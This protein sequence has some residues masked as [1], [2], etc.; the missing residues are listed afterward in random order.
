[1]ENKPQTSWFGS[2]NR[3]EGSEIDPRIDPP[4]H[5]YRKL[6]SGEHGYGSSCDRAS[7]ANDG[8]PSPR[9]RTRTAEKEQSI[10]FPLL[11]LTGRKK[12]DWPL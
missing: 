1:M 4:P 11:Y 6:G 10:R 7:R 8:I 2:R 12:L 9:Y 3:K 5:K